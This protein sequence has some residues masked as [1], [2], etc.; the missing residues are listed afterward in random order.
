MKIIEK[1][2]RRFE[3]Y[4][5]SG[6]LIFRAT[7]VDSIGREGSPPI[8]DYKDGTYSVDLHVTLGG[9]AFS[10]FSRVHIF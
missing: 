3:N 7:L 4:L 10:C 8:S 5:D 1:S 6:W 2:K 9:Y